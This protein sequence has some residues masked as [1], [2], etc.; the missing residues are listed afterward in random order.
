MKLTIVGC[1]GSFPGPDSPA[2]CYLV[3]HDGHR[4][5]LDLGSGALGA[6]QRYTDL[7][8][9]DAVLLSHLH[10]DHVADVGSLYVTRKYHPEGPLPALPVIGPRGVAERIVTMYGDSTPAAMSEIFDFREHTAEQQIGP[11]TVTVMRV[12]HPVIAYATRVEAGGRSLVF[13]GDTGPTDALVDITRGADL[14]L[15]EASFLTEEVAHI[16][17]GAAEIHMTAAQAATQ[18]TLAG[19]DS[20]V[21]THLVPWNSISAI[22]SEARPHFDG[23]LVIARSGLVIDV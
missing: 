22:E 15:F 2:S 10:L 6:L 20:L 21:L 17:D 19:V 14:A 9:I 8:L 13:S 7:R 1:S 4:L 16:V 23:S 3:E 11:F 12:R 18:A 5:V